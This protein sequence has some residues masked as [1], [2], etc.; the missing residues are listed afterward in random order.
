MGFFNFF[1]QDFSEANQ[2]EWAKNE[3]KRDEEDRLRRMKE[4]AK[5]EELEIALAIK[6][7][8]ESSSDA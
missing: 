4:L 6:Q 7:S 8:V 3:S 1:F 5:K 2:M